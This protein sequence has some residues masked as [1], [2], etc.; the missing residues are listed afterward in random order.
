MKN[1]IKYSNS[2]TFWSV[3]GFRQQFSLIE[4][5]EMSLFGADF[6]KN[7]K[8]FIYFLIR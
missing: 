8:G 1:F 4:N 5:I 6:I 7:V 3:G 2:S